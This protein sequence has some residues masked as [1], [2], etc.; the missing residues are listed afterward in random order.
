[1]DRGRSRHY[2]RRPAGRPRKRDNWP[3]DSGSKPRFQGRAAI[4]CADDVPRT[5]RPLAHRTTALRLAGGRG[6]QLALR[7]PRRMEDIDPPR[8][9][10]G[11]AAGILAALPA[12]GLVADEPALF[13]SQRTAAY[14]AAF[15]Q[16]RAAVMFPCTWGPQPADRQRR[17]PPRRPGALTA[18]RPIA[19]RRGA[20]AWPMSRS[21][22][23]MPCSGPQR[24]RLRESVG[25]FAYAAPMAITHQLACVVDDAWQGITDV[26]RGR[27][28]RLTARQIWRPAALPATAHAELPTPAAGGRH[29]R[30]QAVP[31]LPRLADRS[32]RADAAL[33]TGLPGRPLPDLPVGLLDQPLAHALIDFDPA[34]LPHCSGSSIG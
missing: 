4:R 27:P 22:S 25:G 30:Q 34:Q 28:A 3:R 26:V 29:G 13:Q 7:P 1:M 8:E 19:S 31:A 11:A 24:E 2:S 17:H 12:F 6:R 5:L 15:A 18:T 23:S 10:A 33:R 20:C 16:L 9:V 21:T 32:G 14:D